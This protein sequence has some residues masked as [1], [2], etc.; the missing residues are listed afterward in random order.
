MYLNDSASLNLLF[1]SMFLLLIDIIDY[2][3]RIQ[4]VLSYFMLTL[5]ILAI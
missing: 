1:T 4:L 2:C 3:D 5:A